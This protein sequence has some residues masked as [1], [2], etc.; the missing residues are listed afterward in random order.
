MPPQYTLFG[1][2]GALFAKDIMPGVAYLEKYT[3]RSSETPRRFPGWL[4]VHRIASLVIF[5]ST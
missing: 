4:I 5:L 2:T 3:F 1:P